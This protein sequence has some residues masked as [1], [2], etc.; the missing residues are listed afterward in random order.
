MSTAIIIMCQKSDNFSWFLLGEGGG[1]PPLYCN[2]TSQFWATVVTNQLKGKGR[3]GYYLQATNLALAQ[4]Q[5]PVES[6]L[7]QWKIW[8][9]SGQI[10]RLFKQITIR[11]SEKICLNSQP[12]G[13]RG[14]G[15]YTSNMFA[16]KHWVTNGKNQN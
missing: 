11:A 7:G 13:K 6:W 10:N 14:G 4:G 9:N 2:C 12:W 15:G 3:L 5:M 16:I 1:C 8:C